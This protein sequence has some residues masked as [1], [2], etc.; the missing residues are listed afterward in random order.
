LEVESLRS[1]EASVLWQPAPGLDLSATFYSLNVRDSITLVTLPSGLEQFQNTGSM[2]SRGMELEATQLFAGGTQLRASWSLQD[3]LDRETGAALA[4][5][6][7]SLI[8]LMVTAPGPWAGARIG[9]NLQ[10]VGERLTLAGARLAPYVRVNA[11]L[12]HAPIGQPW[13]L[14]LGAYNLTGRRYADPAGPEHLQDSLAQDGRQW[15]MQ[16]GWAF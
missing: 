1:D 11:Q 14:S 6:P 16:F 5:S 8:K 7:L 12:T 10:H 4:D 13:S 15:R 2:R 9:A 3:G